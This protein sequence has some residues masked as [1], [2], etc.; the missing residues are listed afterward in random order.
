MSISHAAPD[1]LASA[2]A[3]FRREHPRYDDTAVLEDLRRTDF[4]RLDRGRHV[5]LDY[6]G[7]GLYAESQLSEHFKLL[8]ENVFGNPHSINATSAASTELLERARGRVL[9][10]F[11]ASPEECGPANGLRHERLRPTRES[12]RTVSAS[13]WGRRRPAPEPQARW[14][15]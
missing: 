2:E 4:A 5:Y 10:F 1:S 13:G 3:A 12:G 9:E 14:P 7:A 8:R 11:R 15:E 6:T